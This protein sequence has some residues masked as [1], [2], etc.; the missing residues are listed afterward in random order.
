MYVATHSHTLAVD[1]ISGRQKW[2]TPIE[3]P[4]DV[5]G[6]LCCGIQS[7][8]L[9]V[10]DGVLY[11]TTLDAHVLALNIDR[12]QDGVE[13]EGRRLQARLQHDARAADRRWHADHRHLRRRVRHARLSR[14]LGP[15]DGREEVA[16]LHHRRTGREGWR[17]LAARPLRK[18]RRADLADR[19]LRSG[20]STSST[21]APATAARGTRRRAAAT[22]STSARCWR[23]VRPPARSSGTTSS[24]PATRTTTTARTN[25]CSPM[26]ADRRQDRRKVLM[27]ANRNGFFYVLDRTSGQLLSA[28]QF[29]KKVNWASGIDLKT[30]RPDRHADDGRRAQDRAGRPTS[31]KSGRARTAARTGCR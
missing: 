7:R 6:Y 14:R 30:G 23:S 13:A 3:L 25:S 31:S 12:R 4:A 16:P 22:R 11:R 24:R 17:H 1:A 26:L 27:Q 5:N 19:D 29:A 9:A 2:K 15:Q 18:R 20:R 28:N 21:G 8:G 10:L